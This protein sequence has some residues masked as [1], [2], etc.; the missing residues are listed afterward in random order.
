MEAVSATQHGD[1]NVVDANVVDANGLSSLLIK[2]VFS[3]SFLGAWV[4]VLSNIVPVKPF[5]SVRVIKGYT[6]KIELN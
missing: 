5:E 1:A 3:C 2:G 6:N 4:R